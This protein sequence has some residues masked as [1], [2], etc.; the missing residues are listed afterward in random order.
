MLQRERGVWY[1]R[2]KE[3]YKTVNKVDAPL[4]LE[5]IVEKHFRHFVK[6]EE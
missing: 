1:A 6:I 4:Q 5:A 3:E 2:M